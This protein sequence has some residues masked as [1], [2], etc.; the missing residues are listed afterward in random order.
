MKKAFL[1]LHLSIFLAG[2]TGVLGKLITL[3]EGLLVWWRLLLTAATMWVLFSLTRKL[4]KVSWRTALE[5]SGVGFLAAMH[6][7]TFYGSIKTANVSV[8]L[9]CFS[10]V[11]FF[12]SLTE[13]L[14][15][16]KPVDFKEVLLGLLVMAGISIIFHFDAR[17]KTGIILGVLCAVLLAFSMVLLRR[18]LK[19][20]N[21][22]T[23]LTYQ[24]SGGFLWLSLLLPLYLYYFPGKLLPGWSN[25]GWLLFLAWFC[26]V[27]AFTLTG[28]ALK[29]LSAYTVNLSFNLEPLYG[30]IL[31]FVLYSEQQE[32]GLSFLVGSSLI[33][34]SVLI[35]TWLVWRRG[36]R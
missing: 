36:K 8:A 9:V 22:E 2:F 19:T 34:L 29:K 3:N 11:G 1:Q 13:P 31:A 28:N 35:H 5:L 23:V 14:L 15:E 30:I 17:Y 21:S 10:S 24:L 26:S 18:Y 25:L 16:K 33:L 6:W 7:V 4:Q 12:T 20:L 27:W 32:L